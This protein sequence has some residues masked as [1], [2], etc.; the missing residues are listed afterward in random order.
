MCCQEKSQLFRVI[1]LFIIFA[2]WLSFTFAD[3][4]MNFTGIVQEPVALSQS[5]E[6]MIL[7]IFQVVVCDKS[8]LLFCATGDLMT[9]A[10]RYFWSV[11]MIFPIVDSSSEGFTESANEDDFVP[12]GTAQKFLWQ[13][14]HHILAH[15]LL[16]CLFEPHKY[17]LYL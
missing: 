12:E 17:I 2:K 9:V 3:S 11:S 7:L 6:F 1:P 10:L 5:N 16:L 8:K 14:L 4:L 13:F 15:H